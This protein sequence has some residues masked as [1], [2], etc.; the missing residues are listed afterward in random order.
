MKENY[1]RLMEQE[2]RSLQIRGE[3]PSLLLHSCCAPCSSAVLESLC[4]Y[5]RVTVLYYNPN[6]LPQAEYARRVG[7]QLRFL[8][9]FSP[10][11]EVAF[12]Q[13]TYE[14]QRFLALAQGLEQEPEGGS[15]CTL[16]YELRL[17]ETAKLAK[18]LSFD[19][20]T[21]TLSVSPYK[22]AEKLNA[23]GGRL[24]SEYEVRYLFSDFKKKGRY[25]RS[26]VLSRDYSLYRQDFCGCP[27]SQAEAQRRK[28][29]SKSKL[30][31][32]EPVRESY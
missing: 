11:A 32:A 27:F 1:E 15:R 10:A 24:S 18:E 31:A 22:D 7:E 21:T 26:L 29:S 9:E 19:Y 5:F 3:I 28:Q 2:I 14:P 16:C 6:I 17:R 23:I 12:L 30:P 4:S 8:R 13:G 25:Q 20:F